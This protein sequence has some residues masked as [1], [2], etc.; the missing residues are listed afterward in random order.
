M[1]ER[2]VL[3][4]VVMGSV[5]FLYFQVLIHQ[6]VALD[7][8]RN[9]VLL[10]MVLFENVH[11][12]NSRSE[13]R[14]AFRHS[15]LRN[16]FLLFGTTAAQLVHIG[17]MYVPWLSDVLAIQPVTPHQ[18]LGVLALSLTVLA[19]MEVHKAVRKLLRTPARQ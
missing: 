7:E 3:A 18:W 11:V 4:A 13:S 10:L 15:P 16:P 19:V 6:G 9:S 1:I 12:F 14:S 17:A 2:V 5:A 8:A